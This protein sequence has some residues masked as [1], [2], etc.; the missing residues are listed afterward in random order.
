MTDVTNF[1]GDRVRATDYKPVWV[2]TW[3]T[4]SRSRARR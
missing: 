4:T 3:L 2:E 1:D